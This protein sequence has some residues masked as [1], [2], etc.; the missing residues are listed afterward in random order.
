MNEVV[1]SKP[2]A[3][4]WLSSRLAIV[5]KLDK[6]KALAGK[7]PE[8]WLLV[9]ILK[10][11]DAQGISVLQATKDVKTSAKVPVPDPTGVAHI[12]ALKAG[13]NLDLGSGVSCRASSIF[14]DDKI[15]AAQYQKL[16]VRYVL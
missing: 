1:L 5:R 3:R 11:K 15:W 13:A 14:R 16:N 8:I 4:Y 7:R 10:V 9:K 6:L 2:G 12:A